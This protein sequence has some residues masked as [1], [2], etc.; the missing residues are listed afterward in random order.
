MEEVAKRTLS[1]DIRDNRKFL[2]EALG[3]DKSFDVIQLDV[4]YSSRDMTFYFIDGF[5]KDE[6]LLHIM[7]E[8]SKLGPD[9]LRTDALP[10]LL[11]RY[12]PYVEIRHRTTRTRSLLRFCPAR[13]L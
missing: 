7:R 5:V 10:K 2:K 6:V 3:V 1:T 12:I 4:E 13:P 9:E 11:K 8:L